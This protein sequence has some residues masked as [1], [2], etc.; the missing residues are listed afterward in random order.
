MLREASV[1]FISDTAGLQSNSYRTWFF[2]G[3]AP[4]HGG[5]L[6]LGLYEEEEDVYCMQCAVLTALLCPRR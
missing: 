3:F 1:S 6:G 2:S 4:V 5:R